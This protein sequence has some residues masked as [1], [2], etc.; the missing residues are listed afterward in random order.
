VETTTP[1]PDAYAR[2]Q[3]LEEL[4]TARQSTDR[5]LSPL[6]APRAAQALR[7]ELASVRAAAATAAGGWERLRRERNS[8]RTAAQRL[9]QEKE[10][11]LLDAKRMRLHYAQVRHRLRPL[12]ASPLAV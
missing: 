2:C 10:R 9:S 3:E 12:V 6:T 4:T 11:L 5:S 7:S 8:S 1:V